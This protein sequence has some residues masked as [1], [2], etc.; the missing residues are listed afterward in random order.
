MFSCLDEFVLFCNFFFL[1]VGCY[2]SLELMQM[3][4]E[5]ALKQLRRTL[6]PHARPVPKFNHPFLPQKYDFFWVNF[7]SKFF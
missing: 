3:E 2:D 4:E 6:V 1:F 7:S 5:K